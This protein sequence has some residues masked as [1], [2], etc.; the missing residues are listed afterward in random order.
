[1]RQRL[2]IEME[3]QEEIIKE[4]VANIEATTIGQIG[5]HQVRGQ[6]MGYSFHKEMLPGRVSGG[7]QI[8]NF[9]NGRRSVH[10]G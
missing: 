2:V 7:I 3:G 10:N 9:L 5:A 8:P 1:M 4:M 6:V